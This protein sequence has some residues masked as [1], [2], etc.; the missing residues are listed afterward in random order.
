MPEPLVE[1]RGV[2]SSYGPVRALHGISMR[3][4]QGSTTAIVGVNGA[5]KTTALNVI[6]GLQD[7]SE[8]EVFYEGKRCSRRARG[9]IRKGM[10]CSPE[11]RGVFP[12]MTVRDN[13]LVGA[14]GVG[15]SAKSDQRM[16]EIF[17][18]FP[19]LKER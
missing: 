11:G 16:E 1:L 18:D 2:H 5:G 6:G 7:I 10:A 13:L 8:G 17:E 15:R 3:I 9:T 14:F 19:L 12:H 4:E